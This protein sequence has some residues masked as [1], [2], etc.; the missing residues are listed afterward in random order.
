LLSWYDSIVVS[1]CEL[2]HYL[3]FQNVTRPGSSPRNEMLRHQPSCSHVGS[4]IPDMRRYLN[5]V[6]DNKSTLTPATYWIVIKLPKPNHR[7]SDNY[8]TDIKDPTN[9][10]R[11]TKDTFT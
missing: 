7:D 1:A 9:W 4:Q 5:S 6:P 3:G 11:C 2:P 10:V 8:A